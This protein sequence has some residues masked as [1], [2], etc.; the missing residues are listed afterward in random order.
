MHWPAQNPDHNP[1]ANLWAS[2]KK[3]LARYDTAPNN[4]EELWARVQ[5]ESSNIPSTLIKKLVCQN[6]LT[7]RS[8]LRGFGI[9]W[10]IIQNI[11]IAS[12]VQKWIH[13]PFRVI[14]LDLFLNDK[15]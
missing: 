15:M 12:N 9:N 13:Q 2:L 11:T 3:S 5:T 6:S 10:N 8:K 4:F 1:I 14:I 7:A